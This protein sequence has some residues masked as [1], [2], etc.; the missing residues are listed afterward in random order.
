MV[1]RRCPQC[2][3]TNDDKYGFC[4]KCGFEFPKIENIKDTCPLCGYVNPKEAEFC[5]KCGAPLIFKN[6]FE[7]NVVTMEPIMVEKEVSGNPEL[8]IG[9]K[10]STWIIVLGYIFS[11]LGGILGLIIA[12]YLSTRKDPVAK[13]HGHIQIAIYG[14]YLILIVILF[15]TGNIP[16]ESIVNYRQILMGNFSSIH[17]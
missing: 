2:G 7:N 1:L 11:I 3:S 8:P 16:T 17:G 9:K 15:A 4:V 13:K 5:V 12:I 10:T 14:F 6:Q